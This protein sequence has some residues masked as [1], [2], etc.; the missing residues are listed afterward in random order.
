MRKIL[1]F[2]LVCF[3]S[4]YQSGLGQAYEISPFS[5]Y[6]L[7]HAFGIQDG[8]AMLSG[9]PHMGVITTICMT[10]YL[11]LEFTYSFRKAIGTAESSQFSESISHS[12]QTQFATLGISKLFPYNVRF[13]FFTGV[14]GGVMLLNTKET[15]LQTLTRVAVGANAGVRYYFNDRIGIRIQAN[16]FM[17]VLEQ[18]MGLWWYS[19]PTNPIGVGKSTAIIQPGIISGII[20][21]IGEL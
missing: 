21:R 2:I 17:P 9:G 13:T 14:N 18:K 19:D 12:T 15:E 7:S 4:A 8:K 10:P 20:F 1:F 3:F 6:T 16:A 11:D 5:G